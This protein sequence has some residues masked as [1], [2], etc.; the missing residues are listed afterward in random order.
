M[1]DDE[2]HLDKIVEQM[3]LAELQDMKKLTPREFAR[4]TGMSP[5]LVYYH[6]RSGKLKTEVCVCGRKVLDVEQ[7]MEAL[8]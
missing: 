5:Q 7:A 1:S 2:G 3:E 4:L 6:I 8:Q